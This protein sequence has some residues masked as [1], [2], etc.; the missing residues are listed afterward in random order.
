SVNENA[1]VRYRDKDKATFFTIKKRLDEIT[2]QTP[3]GGYVSAPDRKARL[4]II[5]S[6]DY[7]TA[8]EIVSDPVP[9]N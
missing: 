9:E 2:L 7:A 8:F 4:A 1:V 5:D 3:D 6:A